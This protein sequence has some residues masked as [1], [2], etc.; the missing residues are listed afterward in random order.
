[1]GEIFSMHGIYEKCT[2]CNNILV[3]NHQ[4][5]I[6]HRA[7]KL[8]EYMLKSVDVLRLPVTLDL[9]SGNKPC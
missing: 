4:W 9:R 8:Q 7:E 1:M 3:G 2:R 6:A 5:K